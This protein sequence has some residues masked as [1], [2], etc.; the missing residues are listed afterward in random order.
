MIQKID[1]NNKRLK[2]AAPA[3]NSRRDL[4]ERVRTFWSE[5]KGVWCSL[6]FE[7]WDRDHS[8]LTEVGW[9]LVRWENG[10]EVLENGHLIVKEYQTF[11]NTYV[12]QHRNVGTTSTLLIDSLTI[13]HHQNYNFG[14]SEVVSKAAFKSLVCDLISRLHQYGP[15]FLVFHDNNQ[16]IKYVDD[17]HSGL[18]VVLMHVAGI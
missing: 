3:L 17:G 5:H 10:K 2:G 1:K 12:P 4:F 13:S 6:D 11:T 18:P 14:E 16:D 9:S 8:I 7:A 15:V